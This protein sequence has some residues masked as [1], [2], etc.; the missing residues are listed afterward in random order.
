VRPH[1]R[2]PASE[3]VTG[4]IRHA[5]RFSP[6][7]RGTQ[8]DFARLRSAAALQGS[9]KMSLARPHTDA[10]VP[11]PRG[12]GPLVLIIEDTT[13]LRDL[14][15]A[16]LATDGFL[17]I[18]AVDGEAGIDKARRFQ[19]DA[20][21]LDLMLPGV[22]GFSVARLLRGDDRTRDVVIVAVTALTSNRLRS[23]AIEAG[24][25]SCLSKP[26]LGADVVRELTRLLVLKQSG[27]DLNR[28][29]R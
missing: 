8:G 2:R 6:G 11:T 17:V 25:D 12:H 21:L 9:L 19:P 28:L 24:C 18:D 14:F 4:R 16:E 27:A 29:K 10:S 23:M 26:V 3:N 15:A 20:I 5:W 1:A 13:D 7:D 22:N